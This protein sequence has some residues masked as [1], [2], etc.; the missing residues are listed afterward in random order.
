MA[1]LPLVYMST[2]SP[3]KHDAVAA[4]ME[5]AGIPVRVDGKKLDSGVEEQPLSM[6]ETYLGA[7]NR[8]DA[9]RALGVDAEYLATVESGLT[10][11]QKGLGT[12]GCV[13]VIIERVGQGTHVGF[14]LSI[15]YPDE[16]LDVVPSKYPD[17]GVWA[18]EAGGASEKDAYSV[19]TNGRLGRR[20]TIENA[21]FHAALGLVL[22]NDRA[23]EA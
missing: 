20:E 21:A 16:V 17:V 19:L 7:K 3:I 5:R 14:E 15:R 13:A 12:Y 10:E 23:I 22:A 18:M 2:A 9:L 4:A 1:E 8:H 11:V 6:D